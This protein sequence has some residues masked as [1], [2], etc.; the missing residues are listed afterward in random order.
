MWVC[1]R[2]REEK[3]VRVRLGERVVG[4]VGEG[5]CVWMGERES[6]YGWVRVRESR[7]PYHTIQNNRIQYKPVEY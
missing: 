5:G 6:V 2:E 4:W 3:C 1:V 7:R